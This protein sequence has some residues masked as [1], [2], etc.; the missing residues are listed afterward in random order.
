MKVE[1]F[2]YVEYNEDYTK[3]KSFKIVPVDKLASLQG[4]R[5]I[6]RVDEAGKEWMLKNG[7]SGFGTTGLPVWNDEMYIEFDNNKEASKALFNKLKEMRVGFELYTSGGRSYHFHIQREI[8][9]NSNVPYTDKTFAEK[10][11]PE[12][13]LSIYKH[14]QPWRLEGTLHQKTGKPKKLLRKLDGNPIV[15]N[16]IEKPQ[17]NLVG[18]SDEAIF[19]D[20]LVMSISTLG[21]NEG[22]RN[23]LLSMLVRKL[24][25]YNTPPEVIEWW[26]RAVN[27]RS[28]PPESE[29]KVN[30]ILR[31]ILGGKR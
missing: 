28:N 8:E 9:P 7:I 11:A 5:S 16:I 21:A 31:C 18:D 12:S 15:L 24:M 25:S 13:D 26:V 1:D 6:Y 17:A 4:F 29:S 30:A 20:E 23:T 14:L 19:D 22:E 2:K 3:R 10:I 27:R